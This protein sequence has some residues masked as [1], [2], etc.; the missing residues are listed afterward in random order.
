MRVQTSTP[1]SMRSTIVFDSAEV[2]F[3]FVPRTPS[4]A[5]G[6]VIE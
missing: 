5:V 2:I 4:T 1:P 6:V 3:S